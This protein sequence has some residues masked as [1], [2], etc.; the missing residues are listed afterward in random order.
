MPFGLCDAPANFQRCITAMFAD[1]VEDIMEV[2][3][4]DFSVY[5]TSFDDCLHNLNNVYKRCE[6]TNLVLTRR[7]EIS[8]RMKELC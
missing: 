7:N 6:D 4:D 5:G 2:F 3:M 8:W 1:F